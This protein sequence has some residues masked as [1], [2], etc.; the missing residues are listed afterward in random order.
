VYINN[1]YAIYHENAFTSVASALKNLCAS[2]SVRSWLTNM[3]LY[4]ICAQYIMR[5][6]LV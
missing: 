3:R 5:K 6:Y 2:T 4:L 1:W